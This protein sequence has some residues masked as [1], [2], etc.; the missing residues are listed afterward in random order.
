M[1]DGSF[2]PFDVYGATVI[3]EDQPRL[4]AVETV[5]A[6]PLLGMALLAGS[7]VKMQVIAG[8]T[9]SIEALP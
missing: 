4:I 1:A 2:Q 6:Q 7:E 9:V 5:D 8:G 3:W